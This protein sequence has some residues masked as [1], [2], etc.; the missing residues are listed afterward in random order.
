MIIDQS[1]IEELVARPSETLSVEIKRWI[2]PSTNHGAFTIV[3]SCFAILNHN[4]GFV[5]F[6]FDNATLL[7]HPDNR[8]LD[9]RA[10]FHTDKI[11]AILSRYAHE[12]FEVGIAFG[13]RDGL[14]HA[15]III[16]P[17]ITA[18]VVVKKD[19]KGRC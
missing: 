13:A 3:R 16:P 2:D 6:G 4:G 9:V 18:P 7:P 12:P 10:S 11:H 8:P 15:V 19:S 1:R 17:G 14:E 5:V